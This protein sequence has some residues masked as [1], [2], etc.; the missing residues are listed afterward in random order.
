MFQVSE[1][2]ESVLAHHIVTFSLSGEW[3]N[4]EADNFRVLL[5]F[6]TQGARRPRGNVTPLLHSRFLAVTGGNNSGVLRVTRRIE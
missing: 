1:L 4:S 5:R 2:G 6:N 3:E